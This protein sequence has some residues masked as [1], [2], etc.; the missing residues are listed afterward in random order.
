[1]ESEAAGI[2]GTGGLSLDTRHPTGLAT[3]TARGDGEAHRFGTL[4]YIIRSG[5]PTSSAEP[6]GSC[7]ALLCDRRRVKLD[8]SKTLR[9]EC[10][11]KQQTSGEV[12]ASSEVS[13][14]RM[15]GNVKILRINGD[16][17]RST[18]PAQLTIS[19]IAL[20]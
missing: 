18:I 6:E 5:C 2:L 9:W 16:A 20:G 1:L 8:C 11:R 12:I 13:F 15:I 14:H 3:S 7:R 4:V 10:C 17:E 19:P